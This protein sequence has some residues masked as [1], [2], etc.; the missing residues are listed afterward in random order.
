MDR[1]QSSVIQ[2]VSQALSYFV[3]LF[4]PLKKHCCPL[5]LICSDCFNWNPHEHC[6]VVTDLLVNF[7]CL[8]PLRPVIA[9]FARFPH[10]CLC[11]IPLLSSGSTFV[12]SKSL[13]M[14]CNSSLVQ[15]LKKHVSL[16]MSFLSLICQDG[17]TCLF[18]SIMFCSCCLVIAFDINT[19]KYIE[20]MIF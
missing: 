9:S 7:Q 2:F 17:N 11:F 19:V 10:S 18:K 6:I 5:G 12:V 14:M 1:N 16:T 3:F 20:I 8:I 15:F 4:F 13:L